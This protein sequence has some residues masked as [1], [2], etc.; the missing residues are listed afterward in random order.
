M[1]L[2]HRINRRETQADAEASFARARS[3]ASGPL[4]RL[5]RAGALLAVCGAGVLASTGTASAKSMSSSF[6]NQSPA[7][8][9][10]TFTNE[11]TGYVAE[12][13]DFNS[14]QGTQ[15]DQWGLNSG[16]NQAW[17]VT[18]NSD[19]TYKLQNRDNGMCLDDA[20]N[21]TQ[22][23]TAIIQWPCNGGL[24]QEWGEVTSPDGHTMLINQRS[25]MALAPSG[26]GQGAGLVQ[27]NYNASDPSQGW[28][29]ARTYYDLL[30]SAISD[31]DAVAVADNS[32]YSCLSGYHFLPFDSDQTTLY[33]DGEYYI[34]ARTQEGDISGDD[35][36]IDGGKAG[37]SNTGINATAGG[38]S[39]SY[40]AEYPYGYIQYYHSTGG[41]QTGQ[42][43]LFCMPN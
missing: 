14:N 20:N 21:S 19:G 40:F 2:F 43:M 4:A 34:P 33:Q 39:L 16:A 13:P 28:T 41:T 31:P 1:S 10:V 35:I 8:Q 29:V 15:M 23:G 37:L 42:S 9:V 3:L 18:Q 11:S 32:N 7:G 17:V 36:G 5:A 22:A 6:E 30:T 12:D 26:S 27:A 24:N 25:D 38:G